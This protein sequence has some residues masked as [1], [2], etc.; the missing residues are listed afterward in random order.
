[1]VYTVKVDQ[2]IPFSTNVPVNQDLSVPIKFE[3][4]DTFPLDAVIPL[5]TT[6]NL[7]VS[8][9]IPVNQTFNAA[10]NVLGQNITLPVSIQ[11]NLPV[12][13]NLAVPFKQDVKIN[14][15]V[16]IKVPV[17]TV[18]KINL[19]QNIPI[20]SQV[21]IKMDVPVTV[22]FK[23]LSGVGTLSTEMDAMANDLAAGSSPLV[24]V[25]VLLVFLVVCGLLVVIFVATRRPAAP[26]PMYTPP[27]PGNV[28]LPEQDRKNKL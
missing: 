6:F 9:T 3:L 16:P 14:T 8:T 11:G 24:V 26:D 10:L 20:Q 23:D 2:T 25:G 27:Y 4:N 17:D 18:I 5:N 7:P 1:M 22:S 15:K 21:P 13:M 28:V 19:S 12:D